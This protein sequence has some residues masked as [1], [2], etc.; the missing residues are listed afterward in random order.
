M[1]LPSQNDEP[2]GKNKVLV[3]CIIGLSCITVAIAC[4]HIA[5]FFV[6]VHF[7]Y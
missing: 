2:W 7:M 3:L 6:D 4:L 5:L 1:Y